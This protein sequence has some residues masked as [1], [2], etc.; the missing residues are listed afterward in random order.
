M[1]V[2]AFP[3]QMS[4]T[5]DRRCR[6]CTKPRRDGTGGHWVQFCASGC[7]CRREDSNLHGV[8]HPTR[9]LAWRSDLGVHRSRHVREVVQQILGSVHGPGLRSFC[10]TLEPGDRSPES[11]DFDD[12]WHS[13]LTGDPSALPGLSK[14]F[15]RMPSPPRCK[16]CGVPFAGPYA[17]VLKMLRFSPWPLNQQLCKWCFEGIGKQRGGAEVPNT[18]ARLGSVTAGGELAMSDAIVEVASVDTQGLERRP[19]YARTTK[20]RLG[21]PFPALLYRVAVTA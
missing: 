21:Y 11:G 3:C 13:L 7:W 19:P 17:P 6:R 15:R 20:L 1:H 9:S 14:R 2:S 4:N 8:T 5:D 10:M 12:H 16:A 18:V